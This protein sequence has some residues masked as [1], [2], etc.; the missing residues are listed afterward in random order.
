[1]MKEGRSFQ[2]RGRGRG[3]SRARGGRGGFHN[4]GGHY[5]SGHSQGAIEAAVQAYLAGRGGQNQARGNATKSRCYKCNELNH[6]A[7]NCPN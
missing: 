2:A 4:R 7:K 5:Q 1:M 6:F 3:G